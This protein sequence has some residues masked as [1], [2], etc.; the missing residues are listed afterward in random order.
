MFKY[1]SHYKY[2]LLILYYLKGGR[3][4][5]QEHTYIYVL[6]CIVDVNILQC[7]CEQLQVTCTEHVFQ[8]ISIKD[9]GEI[10]VVI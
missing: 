3:H 2:Y 1:V 4:G 7:S 5:L 10:N 9:D 6:K 8:L